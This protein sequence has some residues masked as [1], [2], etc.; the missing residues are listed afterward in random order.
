MRKF[1]IILIYVTIPILAGVASY[2]A[3]DYYLF[4]PLDPQNQNTSIFELRPESTFR[5]AAAAL[6]SRNFIRNRMAI[7]LLAKFQKKDTLVMA[8]EYEFS[9][10]MSPQAIL[11]AM[12]EGKMILRTI[13]VKE[14]ATLK[15]IGA[16]V[17]EA[18][19]TTASAFA[20][21]IA[22][23]R[24]LE[25]LK[26][27]A[28]SFEGYLFPETYRIQR[29]TPPSKV[30]RTLKSQLDSKWDPEWNARLI[31]LQ[32]TRH[33]IL[34]LASIIEKESGNA[35]E[36]P[37]VSS[38]FHNRLQRGMKLQSDPTVIYGIP[39]FDGNITKTDLQT[40][41]PYNTYVI[42]G[43][44]PGPIANPGLSAIK[45]ALYPAETLY[46]FF[47]GNGKGQHIFS[48]NLDQHNQA[49]N[50]FQRGIGATIDQKVETQQAPSSVE[51]QH[52]QGM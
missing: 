35:E 19:V 6:E 22:D 50:T 38:V 10:A 33:Q 26:V 11:D 34:T 29:N 51:T 45:A 36:Q 48:E 16:L 52:V 23:A 24:L 37:L 1:A 13:T 39:D 42:T 31:E 3:A 4:A 41:T 12:V 17:E 2:K 46:L 9:P 43:L 44:P 40:A 5:E 28:P 14:G 15:E 18:G 30:I 21:A 49:V 32:M 7:R 47:V 8:G 27:P 25:E 20:D